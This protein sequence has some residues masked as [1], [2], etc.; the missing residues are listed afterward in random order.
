MIRE[1]CIANGRQMFY[2][3]MYESRA[4]TESFVKLDNRDGGM[5]CRLAKG[6][7]IQ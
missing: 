6:A 7:H 3:Q 2:N 5:D 1:I 4:A